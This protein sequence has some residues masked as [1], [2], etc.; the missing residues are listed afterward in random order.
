MV[1]PCIH[2]TYVMH[3]CQGCIAMLQVTIKLIAGFY[4]GGRGTMHCIHACIRGR[5]Q[6]G[7]GRDMYTPPPSSDSA[8]LCQQ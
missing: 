8:T 2:H 4:L 1:R 6:G 5:I 3:S 7:V